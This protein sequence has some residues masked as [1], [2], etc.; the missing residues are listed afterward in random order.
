MNPTRP[1]TLGELKAA[2]YTPR[3]VKDEVRGNLL[4]KLRSGDRLFPGVEGYDDTVIPQIV[5]ALLARQDFILLGLR[6]Q[7]KSRM[8]R[9]L[10]E[11]LDEEIPILAG[12]EV[13]DDPLRPISKY[14]RLQ[15]GRAHV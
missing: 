4:R 14:A 2:G 3:S 1:R 13:N 5:N 15:I 11:L 8:L 12:S 9:Q 6:G 10:V 7:A